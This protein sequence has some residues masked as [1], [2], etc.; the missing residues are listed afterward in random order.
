ME[1]SRSNRKQRKR[2]NRTDHVKERLESIRENS[3]ETAHVAGRDGAEAAI[4]NRVREER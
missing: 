1:E 4:G 3:M 2:G